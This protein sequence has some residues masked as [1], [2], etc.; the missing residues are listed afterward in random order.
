MKNNKQPLKW[1]DRGHRFLFLSLFFFSTSI[2][3]AQV[4]VRGKVV[5]ATGETLI[6]VN[7]I[8]KGTTQGTITDTNG[9]FNLS[10]PSLNSTLIFSYVG[11]VE[12]EIPLN[13]RT[14]LNV[15]LEQDTE[16][17]DEVV[18]VG[19]GTQK[20]VNLTG[21]VQNVSS[22]D[23]VKRNVSNTSIALQ[24]LIPGVSVVTSSGRPGYDG[25]GIKIRGTGSLNSSSNPLILID[26]VIVDAYGLNFIDMNS[27][28]SISVLKDA[29]SASI[30]GSRASN[31]VILITTKRAEEGKLSFNYNGYVGVRTP[32][33]IPEPISAVEYM[34]A[35]NV[36][37]ANADMGPQYSEE[38]IKEYETL[39]PDN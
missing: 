7:V 17:L 19:Y 30:Y 23:L 8:V 9:E 25:A 35:I 33:A 20:K 21:S 15:M 4:N 34:R 24:G 12:Q 6:G 3:Q 22:A 36:A 10:V 39:G 38:L 18:V 29:A 28:A 26:G 37:R 13:G 27:I 11:Y 14:Y 1:K 5:D 31:G 32:T 16:L 2:L